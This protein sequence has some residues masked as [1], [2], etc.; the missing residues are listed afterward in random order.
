MQKLPQ[1]LA[2]LLLPEVLMVQSEPGV[3]FANQ[4]TSFSTEDDRDSKQ[5]CES[6]LDGFDAAAGS[7]LGMSGEPR[8]ALH[9]CCIRASLAC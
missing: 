4:C 2:K 9:A 8:H 5:S 7:D 3:R 1:E 6:G